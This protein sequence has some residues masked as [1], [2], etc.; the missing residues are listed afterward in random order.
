MEEEKKVS[1]KD[2]W[3]QQD[4]V[5][6]VGWG[7]AFIWGALV[8]L[9]EITNFMT[10]FNWW[11]G[12]G[13]FFTGA[14]VITLIGTVIRL[15][16]PAYRAKWVGSLIFGLILLAIGLGTWEVWGWLWVVVLFF[17]GIIILREVFVRKS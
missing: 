1:H 2:D 8:L 13:V 14:G 12:W 9:A 7:M 6:A 10:N 3:W 15:Q 5:D 4:K 16:M 17:V 11:D